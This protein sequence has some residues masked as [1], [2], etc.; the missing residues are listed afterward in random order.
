MNG[1]TW[2]AKITVA[3]VWID[4]GFDLDSEMLHQAI[5]ETLLSYAQDSEIVCEVKPGPNPKHQPGLNANVKQA[6]PNGRFT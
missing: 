6:Y 4:D 1:K 3:Q 5:S 2:T